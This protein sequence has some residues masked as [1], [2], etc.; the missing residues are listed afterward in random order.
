MVELSWIDAFRSGEIPGSFRSRDDQ[1]RGDG[2]ERGEVKKVRSEK[3]GRYTLC[4]VPARRPLMP[5]VIRRENSCR[6]QLLK[7][8]SRMAIQRGCVLPSYQIGLEKLFLGQG[9]N[10]KKC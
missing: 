6:Q 1:L 3:D 5:A 9:V 4:P 8:F 2:S 10:L 7:F